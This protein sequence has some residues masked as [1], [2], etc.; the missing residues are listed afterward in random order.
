MNALHWIYFGD[1]P[2]SQGTIDEWV[3]TTKFKP[4]NR[5]LI[6]KIFSA[7]LDRRPIGQ[8]EWDKI[9]CPVLI[10]HGG[11]HGTPSLLSAALNPDPTGED[12]PAP[13][14][15]AQQFYDLL[16]NADREI[17]IIDGAPHFLT[18]T[19]YRQVCLFLLL[20]NRI[21]L[22]YLFPRSTHSLRISLTKSQELTQNKQSTF[23]CH[24]P[25]SCY[26]TVTS[27]SQ[28][29]RASL[30]GLVSRSKACNPVRSP[31]IHQLHFI[32]VSPVNVLKD[33]N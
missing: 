29:N 12:V 19:H 8:K 6:D 14:A 27:R 10:I 32:V 31:L 13:P 16:R 30:G 28:R 15:V 5:K 18:H 25:S 11:K 7:V 1:D 21:T 17:H 20:R 23:R 24:K 3:S 22:T 33:V 2:S 9:T 26:L 4:S